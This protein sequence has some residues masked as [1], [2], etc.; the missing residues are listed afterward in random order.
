MQNVYVC[1]PYDAQHKRPAPQL[2]IDVPK[3]LQR[4]T[5]WKTYMWDSTDGHLFSVILYRL[6][7]LG[8]MSKYVNFISTATFY[9]PPIYWMHGMW[10]CMQLSNIERWIYTQESWVHLENTF[11][12]SGVH[13][14][15][16]CSVGF[17]TSE[18]FHIVSFPPWHPW[19]SH[20]TSYCACQAAA[21]L[22]TAL[23][24]PPQLL[25]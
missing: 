10:R 22:A 5:V 18:A 3:D 19:I 25:L 16:W 14:T 4:L 7:C 13:F 20:I 24:C 23:L 12:P 1:S 21:N 6:A 17:K 8:W 9:S 15:A 2:L 11:F